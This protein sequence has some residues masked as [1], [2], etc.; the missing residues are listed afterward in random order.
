MAVTLQDPTSPRDPSSRHAFPEVAPEATLEAP[1]TLAEELLSVTTQAYRPHS[2]Q[3]YQPPAA[4]SRTNVVLR[5]QRA[6]VRVW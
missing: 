1:R 6:H 3:A 2:M 4:S 5:P